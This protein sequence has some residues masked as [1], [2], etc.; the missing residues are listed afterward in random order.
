MPRRFV[1]LDVFTSRPLTGNPLAVVLDSGGL[2][3]TAMQAIAR[4]FNLP[5]T[6]FVLAPSDA[7]AR[8]KLRIFTPGRE[9]AFAGHPTVGAAVLLGA[10]QDNGATELVLE[11]NVGP[12][13]CAVERIDRERGRAR[14]DVPQQPLPDDDIGDASD[15]AAA[16]SLTLD[17]LGCDGF[18]PAT[19]SAGNPVTF[20][21]VRGLD[22]VQ[23]AAVDSASWERGF[24]A[25]ERPIAYVFLPRN[26]GPRTSIS[27]AHVC[28]CAWCP[29]GSCDRIGRG[30]IRRHAC[31]RRRVAGRRPSL[32]D[33]A[34][35]RDGQAERDAFGT[36]DARAHVA[37]CLRR[38]RGRACHAGYDRRMNES[39]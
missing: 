35:L 17:D 15:V 31:A 6:V 10:L 27:R 28:A 23:R 20:L 21:P 26:R 4:E 37:R 29:R 5:E 12:V 18:V 38:R 14:F 24:P 13:H 7:S 39:P 9:L 8:A 2:A 32:R 30:G 3:S 22:A 1:T 16:L 36:D 11:E 33:R 34:G 25:N 19:W